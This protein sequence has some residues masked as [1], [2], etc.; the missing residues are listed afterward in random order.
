MRRLRKTRHLK[1]NKLLKAR[2]IKLNYTLASRTLRKQTN[3]KRISNLGLFKVSGN[4]TNYFLK[5]LKPSVFFSYLYINKVMTS[6]LP[7]LIVPKSTDSTPKYDLDTKSLL[8]LSDSLLKKIVP[9]VITSRRAG[10][11]FL[12]FSWSAE[13]ILVKGNID[14]RSLTYSYNYVLTSAMLK[15]HSCSYFKLFYRKLYLSKL[16]KSKQ[17]LLTCFKY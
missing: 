4:L 15:V 17:L 11:E 7:N 10:L 16:A 3:K 2:V 1:F 8:V 5:F 12:L 13:S 14:I 9:S 6:M